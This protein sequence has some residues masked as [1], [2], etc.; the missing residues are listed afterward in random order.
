M[1]LLHAGERK[2]P[3]KMVHE[4]QE[5]FAKQLDVLGGYTVQPEPGTD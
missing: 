3:E 2:V 1:S 4:V 5:A